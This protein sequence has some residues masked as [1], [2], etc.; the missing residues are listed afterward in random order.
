MPQ[1]G[2]HL[3]SNSQEVGRWHDSRSFLDLG[4]CVI[5]VA[6]KGLGGSIVVE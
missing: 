3:P 5:E 2:K 4:M 6:W 1:A